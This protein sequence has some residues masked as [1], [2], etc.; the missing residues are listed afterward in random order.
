M[1][2]QLKF[3]MP[4]AKNA[5][6]FQ[7]PLPRRRENTKKSNASVAPPLAYSRDEAANMLG[8]STPT[9]DR[10]AKEGAISPSRIK[11]C[12]RYSVV[13]LQAFLERTKVSSK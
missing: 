13:E 3:H 8:I 12:V 11:G 5:L 9:L 6:A 2:T 1:A 4:P 7:F 10:L